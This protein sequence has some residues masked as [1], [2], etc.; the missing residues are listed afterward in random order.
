MTLK[1]FGEFVETNK[2][3]LQDFGEFINTNRGNFQ[4]VEE[5]RVPGIRSIIKGAHKAVTS[6]PTYM[7]GPISPELSEKILEKS[8]PTPKKGLYPYVESIS[9]GAASGSKFGLPG[10]IAGGIGGGLKELAKQKNAPRWVQTLAEIAPWLFTEG[11]LVPKKNQKIVYNFL[12]K[13][14]FNDKEITPLL[15]GSKKLSF[16]G[17]LGAKGGRLEENLQNISDRFQKSYNKFRI[18]GKDLPLSGNSIKNFEENFEKIWKDIPVDQ[19]KLLNELKEEL[20]SKPITRATMQDFFHGINRQIYGKG[21][22]GKKELLTELKNPIYE[23]MELIEKGSGEEFKLLNELNEKK[24]EILKKLSPDKVDKFFSLTETLGLA[25]AIASGN[26]SYIASIIGEHAARMLIREISINP[27]L[28][29]IST[30]MTQAATKNQAAIVEKL[31]NK[32]KDDI[33]KQNKKLS[34]KLE[35]QQQ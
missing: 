3:G 17:K 35:S 18:E 25:G 23:G 27:R 20:F 1:E 2:E 7:G 4:G 13:Q 26:I 10:T 24:F 12:K 6:L 19:R 28:Q 5:K 34:H 14:G 29:N 15:Q 31:Y 21:A 11:G 32:F 30:K 8:L 9:E 33:S 16:S 22:V